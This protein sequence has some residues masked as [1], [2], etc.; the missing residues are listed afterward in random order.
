MKEP[1]AAVLGSAA[2]AFRVVTPRDKP[3]AGRDEAPAGPFGSLHQTPPSL[4]E[5]RLEEQLRSTSISLGP[6]AEA[7]HL[8]MTKL[9]GPLD[10]LYRYPLEAPLPF[11]AGWP[12]LPPLCWSL[13]PY[14]LTPAP[15]RS[16]SPSTSAGGRS[17]SDGEEPPPP[18]LVPPPPPPPPLPP[19]VCSAAGR[20]PAEEPLKLS[21]LTPMTSAGRSPSYLSPP[22]S[23]LAGRSSPM[24]PLKPAPLEARPTTKLPQPYL[25]PPRSLLPPLAWLHPLLLRDKE[26]QERLRS[27]L[28]QPP[29]PLY[30]PISVGERPLDLERSLGPALLP[31]KPPPEPLMY[32]P[33]RSALPPPSGPLRPLIGELFSC[34]KCQKMFSTPHGLEVHARRSH[35]GK[36]PFSCD[37]C[38]KTF[39]HEVSLS[40]HR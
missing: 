27:Y 31:P 22:H 28:L 25:P 7:A 14:G 1:A 24:D 23:A 20:S 4:A 18:P 36:R 10:S 39:G 8:S 38:S 34:A 16:G 11:R 26:E 30:P 33:W 9:G 13:P 5:R 37:H 6:A 12:L 19:P 15:P 21:P 29:P 35:N 3:D 32:D 17:A 40:Q 2:S